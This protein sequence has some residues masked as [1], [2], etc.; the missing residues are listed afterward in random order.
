ME[1]SRVVEILQ[2]G[3]SRGSGYLI[4]P[5]HVLTARH[6]PKPAVVGTDCA[7]HPLRRAAEPAVPSAQEH[8]PQPVPAKVGW[9][10]AAHDFA[11]IEITGDPL[12]SPNTGSIPF[13]VV[14]NDGV[15]RQIIGS[16][17][18]EAAGVDQ[19]TIIGTLTWVL[20]HLGR[21]D[22][23]VISAIPR[24]W[25]KWGGFS[26]AAIFVDNILVGVVRTVDENWNGG[27]LEATP[28]VWLLD[29]SGFK[30]YLEDAGLSLP[31]RLDVGAADRIMPLDFEADVSIEGTL[32]FSPRNQ[33]VPFLGRETTLR[34]LEE[35]LI[36][37]QKHPFSWW[38]VTGGGGAGKTRLARELCL[39]TRR[40]GWRAG[41]MPSSFVT[42]T[43]SLDAWCPRTPTLIVADYVMKRIEQIRELSAR[44]ARRDGLPPLRLL[45]LERVADKPFENQFLGSAHSDRAVIERARYQP[46]P[47]SL[48]GLTE[49]EVW[50]IVE[51]C[52]W[53]SDAARVPHSRDEFFRRL[54]QLDSQRWPL[55][56]MILADALASSR[57]NAG[58]GGL[59]TVLQDLLTRDRDHLWPRDLWCGQ[60]RSRKDRSGHRHCVRDDGRR[61]RPARA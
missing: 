10:S 48:P 21:F 13:G 34:T 16:G 60:Y 52:P 32:R 27:V 6:V 43:A 50:S 39:R 51:A 56:A 61:P 47:L 29:D 11:L 57:A 30:S 19:R 40:R 24:D 25:T 12:C 2:D 49:D 4:A 3:K 26:G 44:L 41:F 5:H 7:A 31:D 1:P 37:E 59:E 15:A 17:F 53:R 54:S 18:P 14:P 42:D 22:I 8:R 55:V 33:R 46:E 20:T 9:V 58:L 23:D 38:L 35:F 28:A 36:T 45:L